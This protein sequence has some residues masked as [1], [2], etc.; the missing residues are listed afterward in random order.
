MTDYD[1]EVEVFWDADGEPSVFG[2][3]T[4]KGTYLYSA[5]ELRGTSL[6]DL[7]DQ[8]KVTVYGQE[9]LYTPEEH[10]EQYGW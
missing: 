4:R 2:I 5:E 7:I 10:F 8:R 9:Q 6:L 3:K 1:I